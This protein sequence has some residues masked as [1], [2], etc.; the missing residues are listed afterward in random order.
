MVL[1]PGVFSGLLCTLSMLRILPVSFASLLLLSA[2]LGGKQA[3]GLTVGSDSPAGE[4]VT[5]I[6]ALPKGPVKDPE[7][8]REVSLAYG[9]VS[10]IGTI[11]ANGIATAHYFADGSTIVVVQANILPAGEGMFYEVWMEGRSPAD[12]ISI[13]HM[14]NSLSDARHSLKFESSENLKSYKKIIISLEEDNGN[15]SL[16]LMAAQAILKETRR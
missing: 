8:G 9:A 2:C 1:F 4:E 14:Q 7:R 10:G 5:I 13:G 16:S 15:P 11:N 6:D 3:V 12:R